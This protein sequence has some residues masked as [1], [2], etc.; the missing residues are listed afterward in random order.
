VKRGRKKSCRGEE[1][2]QRFAG[3]IQLLSKTL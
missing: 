2:A 1:L 3:L